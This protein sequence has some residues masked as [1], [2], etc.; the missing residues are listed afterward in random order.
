MTTA[1]SQPVPGNLPGAHLGLAWESL[2][3]VP[4]EEIAELCKRCALA[5]GA[6]YL[7]PLGLVE[8]IY[9]PAGPEHVSIGGRSSDGVL[10]AIA[11]A[12]VGATPVSEDVSIRAMVDPTWRGR[13]IGRSLLTWQDG[14]ALNI[15]ENRRRPSIIAVPIAASLMDR[16]RLYTAGGLSFVARLELR[17][18]ILGDSPEVNANHLEPPPPA[19]G[20]TTRRMEDGDREALE[21]L[22]RE[23]CRDRYA[24]VAR[25]V[26][27]PDLV[28]LCDPRISRVAER[29]G[30]LLGAVL[31]LPATG[32]DGRPLALVVGLMLKAEDE[33]VALGLSTLR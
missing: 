4:T 26:S 31:S 12:R 7:L 29:K 13:G 24:F 18:R 30:E 14:L 23:E 1:H 15:L 19:P 25:G 33:R 17:S 6:A 9:Q 22:H 3:N 2:E 27:I 8:K 11:T 21:R 10:R 5:D 32:T 20:W 16:R 28:S